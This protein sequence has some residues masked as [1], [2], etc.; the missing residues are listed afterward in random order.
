MLMRDVYII[1]TLIVRNIS[2]ESYIGIAI[3]LHDECKCVG[4]I[5]KFHWN[6]ND[7]Q[8]RWKSSHFITYLNITFFHWY[9]NMIKRQI[10]FRELMS[11][12]LLPEMV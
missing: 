7:T 12:L 2:N 6:V 4:I 5:V 8:L 10:V 1:V 9:K 11:A 3:P